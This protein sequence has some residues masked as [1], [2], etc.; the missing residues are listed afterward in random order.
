MQYVFE[1]QVHTYMNSENLNA[2]G[3]CCDGRRRQQCRVGCR[4]FFQF[5]LRLAG[6]SAQSSSCPLGLLQFNVDREDDD[7]VFS[8]DSSISNGVALENPLVFE[9]RRGQ[10]WP[11]STGNKFTPASQCL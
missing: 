8:N 5:C 3:Q 2:F 9:G 10:P 7:I 4:N 1:V 11:V 6:T